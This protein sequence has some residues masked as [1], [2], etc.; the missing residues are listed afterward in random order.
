MNKDVK[1]L[2]KIISDKGFVSKELLDK[3][4]I[5]YDGRDE[6]SSAKWT[7]DKKI[8]ILASLKYI[9]VL[10][11]R[12]YPKFRATPAGEDYLQSDENTS[13]NIRWLVITSILSII[14]GFLGGYFLKQ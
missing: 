14:A 10:G 1:K 4:T 6:K 5:K 9:E 11:E 7:S 2:L 13:K 3:S 12:A 8:E